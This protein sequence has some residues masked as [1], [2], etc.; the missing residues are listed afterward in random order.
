MRR[1]AFE[2]DYDLQLNLTPTVYVRQLQSE[3]PDDQNEEMVEVVSRGQQMS[4]E[5]YDLNLN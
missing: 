3:E 5:P 2:D 1:K 4:Y